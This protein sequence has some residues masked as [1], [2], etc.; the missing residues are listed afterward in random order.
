MPLSLIQQQKLTQEQIQLQTAM[1]V[2][3]SKLVEL[4]LE[5]LRERVATELAE[6]PYLEASNSENGDGYLQADGVTGEVSAG[7][8]DARQDYSS[9]DDIPDYLLHQS[10]G[11]ETENNGMDS[12]DTQSFYELLMEQAGGCDLSE[13]DR[14]ILEYL[15]GN[16]GDDGLLGKPL[17]QIAD[18]LSIYHYCDTTP[19]EVERILHILWR[20]DPPGVGARNLQECLII[21]CKRKGYRSVP[22]HT[23]LLLKVLERNWEDI[24]HNRWDLI[25][26]KYKLSDQ[27]VQ[28]LRHEIRRLN[29]RPGSSM[30]EKPNSAETQITPDVIVGVDQEGNIDLTLNDGDMPTLSVSDDA[31]EMIDVDFVRD[32]VNRGR[33]FIGAI[34]QRRHT[35]MRTMQAIIKL[36]RKYLLTGDET[37]LRPMRLEDI[38][39]IT[40]QDLSTVSR[41]CNSKYVETPYGTYPL[42]WFFTTQAKAAKE[43]VSIKKMHQALKEIIEQEDKSHPL[44]D[45]VLAEM[46]QQKG[47]DVARRTVAKYREQLGIPTSRMRRA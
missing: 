44:Q 42:R 22:G 33:L 15:I 37:L 26:Q 45:D 12:A 4:P 27:Q 32:Y 11:N 29:P 9:E 18:E 36:Q 24:S 47:F 35:I 16:L 43:D 34:I 21:Q 17:F 41:V 30:G 19:E 46:L 2:L 8:Y 5:G 28:M 13:H 6:N 3:A 31:M 10:S 20:F 38:A 7:E 23:P 14:Q 1:Q 40:E 25:Q 39:K